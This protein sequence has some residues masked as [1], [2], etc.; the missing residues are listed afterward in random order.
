MTAAADFVV[1]DELS[2]LHPPK[3]LQPELWNGQGQRQ[4]HLGDRHSTRPTDANGSKRTW[5]DHQ[6]LGATCWYPFLDHFYLWILDEV[7]DDVLELCMV[8]DMLDFYV[9]IA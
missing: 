6:L 2:K 8:F 9:W 3:Q 5:R 7:I 1:V 4:K